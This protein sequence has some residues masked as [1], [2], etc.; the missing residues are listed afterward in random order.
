MK[1][2]SA[3]LLLVLFPLLSLC[4]TLA[5]AENKPE[6]AELRIVVPEGVAEIDL[7][8]ALGDDAS[9]VS[10][11]WMLNAD[12]CVLLRVPPEDEDYEILLL[13]T[14]NCSILSRTPVPYAGSLFEQGWDDGEFY[15]LFEPEGSGV[16]YDHE[17]YFMYNPEITYIKAIVAADGTV[18]FGRASSKLTIMPDGET[19]IREGHYGSLYAVDMDTGEEKLLIQ[20][21]AG[22]YGVVSYKAYLKYVP[23]WDDAGFYEQDEN[24]NPRSIPF[25]LD[26]DSFYAHTPFFYHEFT[27]YRPL[28][29]HRFVYEGYGWEWGA[30][31][32]VYDL[33]T[34]TDHRITGEGDFYGMSG[35]MLFGSTL[36]ADANTYESSP[37]PKTVQ[38][39]FEEVSAWEDGVVD[40]SI[41]PD[42]RLLALTGMKSRRSDAS[43][44]TITDIRTGNIIKAYDI[45]NPFATEYSVAFYDDTHFLLFCAP[46]ELGSAYIYLFNVNQE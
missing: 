26:E 13:D 45:Y 46:E 31:F 7:R 4:P 21:T 12:I 38:E 18:G 5:D 37:L 27:V 15:L 30:G 41:S 9:G 14:R 1:K 36:M 40:C 28:D 16:L 11:A 42:G 44:V 2:R 22:P 6:P 34:H 35:G 32:G 25:P 24:G 10:D 29:E 19:A 20:G 33:Q 3:L 8:V 39:Q 23:F 17:Y 43:T